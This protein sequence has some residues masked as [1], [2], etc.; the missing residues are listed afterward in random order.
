M[1]VPKRKRERNHMIIMAEILELAR[2][3]VLK[4][5]IMY[6]V[7]MS[8]AQLMEYLKL[9]LGMKCLEVIQDKESNRTAYRTTKQGLRYLTLYNEIKQL[10]SKYPIEED[11]LLQVAEDRR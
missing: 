10:L 2:N 5:H 6:R 9:L 1:A 3:P 7:R 11:S 8:Y 4:T